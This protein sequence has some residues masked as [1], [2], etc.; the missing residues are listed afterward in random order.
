[1]SDHPN[2][3]CEDDVWSSKKR[4]IL[5]REILNVQTIDVLAAYICTKNQFGGGI[6]FNPNL[7]TR[8]RL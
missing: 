1:L 8:Q 4:N 5:S 3:E 7:K 6:N 2:D